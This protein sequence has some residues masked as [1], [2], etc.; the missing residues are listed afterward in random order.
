MCFE[1][2][3]WPPMIT[4]QGRGDTGAVGAT[5]RW[6]W[7]K[8]LMSHQ[9]FL[10]KVNSNWA[11]FFSPTNTLQHS[12]SNWQKKFSAR[13]KWLGERSQT[14]FKKLLYL[15]LSSIRT[16]YYLKNVTTKST[17]QILAHF[18]MLPPQKPPNITVENCHFAVHCPNI[19]LI[20]E[21]T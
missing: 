14:W 20:K 19:S 5:L 12:G 16:F 1:K 3:T 15:K 8:R 9:S 18:T 2:K 17:N 7:L 13:K 21:F 4:L 11:Q 6:L 10:F